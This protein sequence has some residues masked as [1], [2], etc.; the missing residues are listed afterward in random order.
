MVVV[1][2]VVVEVEVVTAGAVVV[3]TPASAGVVTTGAASI[4][5][6]IEAVAVPAVAP[7]AVI[8]TVAVEAAVGVPDTTPVDELNDKPAGRVPL[9]TAYDTEPVKFDA[10]NAV[11][12]AIAVSAVPTI[13][14]V[15]GA[16]AALTKE[17][18]DEFVSVPASVVTLI[19]V[20]PSWP[21]GVTAV[22]WVAEFTMYEVAG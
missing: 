16:K 13:C 4:A 12:E 8:V 2:V 10:V 9:V 11:D 19:E 7:L 6:V 5:N 21:V 3:V 1:V 14:C 17:N 18:R 15:W 22:I 20:E